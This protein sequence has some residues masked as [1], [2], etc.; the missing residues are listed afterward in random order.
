[1]ATPLKRL[2]HLFEPAVVSVDVP[3]LERT[4]ANSLAGDGVERLMVDPRGAGDSGVGAARISAQQDARSEHRDLRADRASRHIVQDRITSRSFT[5]SSDQHRHQF[6]EWRASPT[7][8]RR[9]VPCLPWL[10]EKDADFVATLATKKFLELDGTTV[11]VEMVWRI[12]IGLSL[13]RPETRRC[14]TGVLVA[15]RGPRSR[16]LSQIRGSLHEWPEGRTPRAC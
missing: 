10:K 2:I 14:T 13:W 6:V 7:G 1:V 3:N 16:E 11:S 5:I 12:Q 15:A 8:S 9:R 4:V